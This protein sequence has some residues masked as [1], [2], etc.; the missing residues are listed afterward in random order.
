MPTAGVLILLLST[1][2]ACAFRRICLLGGRLKELGNKGPIE[3]SNPTSVKKLVDPLT[4]RFENLEIIPRHCMLPFGSRAQQ[5]A[6]EDFIR[7]KSRVSKV[8][9]L[10]TDLDACLFEGMG[11]DDIVKVPT[12]EES[13]L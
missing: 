10:Q 3:I 1:A 6:E 12:I 5:D 8:S 2:S 13:E 4:G 9:S 11:E 7:S